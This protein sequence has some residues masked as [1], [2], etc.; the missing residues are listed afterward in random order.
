LIKKIFIIRIKKCITITSLRGL[1]Q[2]PTQ[3]LPAS[4]EMI[5][6]AL[7]EIEPKL[8]KLREQLQEEESMRQKI[9]RSTVRDL[10]TTVLKY[11]P[12]DSPFETSFFVEEGTQYLYLHSIKHTAKPIPFKISSEQ[13]ATLMR[14][15]NE[16]YY[17]FNYSTI[18]NR[19]IKGCV[20]H[21][22]EFLRHMYTLTLK[23][24]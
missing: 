7:E 3:T 8:H 4:T 17:L 16:W 10:V 15:Q 11:V 22:K 6:Q 13:Q 14:L 18:D 19:S 1:H 20:T 21:E 23:Y 9:V 12:N 5:Q 2:D 24:I